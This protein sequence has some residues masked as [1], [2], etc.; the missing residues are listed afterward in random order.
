MYSPSRETTIQTIRPL[1]NE[2]EEISLNPSRKQG[3]N[4]VLRII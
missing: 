1:M 4:G 2:E 3:E